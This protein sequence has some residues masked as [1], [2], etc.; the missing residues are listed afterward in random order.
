M[1]EI[2][3]T[4]IVLFTIIIAVGLGAWHFHRKVEELRNVIG[5]FG[6]TLAEYIEHNEHTVK[7]I[8]GIF[9]LSD[10]VKFGSDQDDVIGVWNV[11]DEQWRWAS[12]EDAEASETQVH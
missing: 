4:E 12:E 9:L 3:Q 5:A 1:I 7:S 6:A 8:R 10:L 11:Q 2:T